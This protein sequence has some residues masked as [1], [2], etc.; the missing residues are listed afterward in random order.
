MK[1]VKRNETNKEKE[2]IHTENYK[3]K[4]NMDRNGKRKQKNGKKHELNKKKSKNEGD[5]EVGW[6]ED[7]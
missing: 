5:G 3:E 4:T 2:R 1:H 7:A 6:R